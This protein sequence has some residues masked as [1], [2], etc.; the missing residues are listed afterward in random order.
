MENPG[1]QNIENNI[2]VGAREVI[3]LIFYSSEEEIGS[4]KENT[5]VTTNDDEEEEH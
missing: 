5:Y 4:D 2:N 3:D 1:N